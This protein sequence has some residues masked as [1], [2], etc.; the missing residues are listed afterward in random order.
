[1]R[2]A[3]MLSM[4]PELWIKSYQNRCPRST[5][6]CVQ[7]GMKYA[8]MPYGFPP[9]RERQSGGLAARRYSNVLVFLHAAGGMPTMR[10]KA[11][12]NA[13]SES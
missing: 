10:L 4:S 9:S 7:I 12:E 3:V 13:A 2:V 11:R 1:V 6:M 8:A 5:G